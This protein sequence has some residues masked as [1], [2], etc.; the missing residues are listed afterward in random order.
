MQVLMDMELKSDEVEDVKGTLK[1]M[2]KNRFPS[3]KYPLVERDGDQDVPVA[4]GIA[5]TL[6]KAAKVVWNRGLLKPSQNLSR[7]M[8]GG[9]N[10]YSLFEGKGGIDDG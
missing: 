6:A 3:G 1:Y 10:P 9:D 8:H 7:E 2:I 4:P 5:L